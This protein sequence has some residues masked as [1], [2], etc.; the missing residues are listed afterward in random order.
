[1]RRAM[2]LDDGQV[3]AMSLLLNASDDAIAF[4]LPPPHADRVVLIDSTKPDQGE[5]AFEDE[6]ELG[7]HGAALV[8]W[9]IDGE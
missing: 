2:T 7:A 6:Y 8:R 5:V 3:E 9:R 4:H 1:M